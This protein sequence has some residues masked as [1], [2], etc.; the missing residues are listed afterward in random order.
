[1]Y[2]SAGKHGVIGF[3]VPEEFG[4]GG[5]DDFRFGR[6][7]YQLMHNLPAERMSIAVS[8]VAGARAIFSETVEYAKDRTAFGQPI[9]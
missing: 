6:G 1:V 4:G 9:G 8:A 2:Q 5:V 3:N 7:F